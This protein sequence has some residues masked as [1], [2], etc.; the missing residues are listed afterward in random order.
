MRPPAGKST[1]NR[2]ELGTGAN[3]RYKKITFWKEAI[4]ELLVKVFLESHPR[5]PAEIVVDL[6]TADLPLHGPR[7]VDSSTATTTNTAICRSTSFAESTFCARAC[8]NPITTL[9]SAACRKSKEW[10]RRFGR[11]G[12]R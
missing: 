6:D 10:W 11:P 2:M 8:G 1:L 7:R 5:A 12:R 3:D 4:D 9:P